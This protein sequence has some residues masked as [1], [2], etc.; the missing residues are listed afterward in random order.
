LQSSLAKDDSAEALRPTFAK[1]QDTIKKAQKLLAGD[2]KPVLAAEQKAAGIR[3]RIDGLLAEVEGYLRVLRADILQ[4]SAPSMFSTEY[5]AAFSRG[6]WEETKKGLEDTSWSK[7]QFFE[8]DGLKLA[9]QVFL[10]LILIAFILR[11]RS[12]L[13]QSRACVFL[14]KDR[15]PLAC[16]PAS[17]RLHFSTAQV[18]AHGVWSLGPS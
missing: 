9:L 16:S 3:A 18:A 15:S 7:S 11:K 6:L 4:R 5:H 14:P 13:P 1:A 12:F 10:S 2:L 17:R 8:R